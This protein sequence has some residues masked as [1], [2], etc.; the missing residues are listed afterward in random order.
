[1]CNI[2]HRVESEG[3]L[4][5]WCSVDGNGIKWN[6]FDLVICFE[7]TVLF[8]F[9]STIKIAKANTFILKVKRVQSS[10]FVILKTKR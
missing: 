6:S 3:L 7:T 9:I 10:Y 1:M 5:N 8:I 2:R 4:S